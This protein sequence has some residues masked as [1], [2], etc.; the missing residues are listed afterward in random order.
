MLKVEKDG[1]TISQADNGHVMICKDNKML[2]H[3]QNK[4]KYKNGKELLVELDHYFTILEIT[5]KYLEEAKDEV[6]K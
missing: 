1:Y 5:N 6:N 2:F 3:G 4:H